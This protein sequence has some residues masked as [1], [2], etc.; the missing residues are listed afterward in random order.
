[1]ETWGTDGN[2]VNE[3]RGGE[4][5]KRGS[6]GW[7]PTCELRI[8]GGSQAKEKRESRGGGRSFLRVLQDP[9][10]SFIL[11]HNLIKPLTH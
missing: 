6:Y 2:P 7:P 9:G 5:R 1:M 4:F 3:P 8:V 10:E 11:L